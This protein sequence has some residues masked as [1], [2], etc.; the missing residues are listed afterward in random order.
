MCILAI[1]LYLSIGLNFILLHRITENSKIPIWLYL[2]SVLIWPIV[3][4]I[5]LFIYILDGE[6]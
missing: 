5:R 2:L 1:L 3:A 4:F 6:I